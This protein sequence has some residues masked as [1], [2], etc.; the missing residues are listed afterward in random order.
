M[1][2]QEVRDGAIII[3]IIITTNTL[4]LAIVTV[5]ATGP[6]TTNLKKANKVN[7]GDRKVRTDSGVSSL[8]PCR[9]QQQFLQTVR[10]SDEIEE[11]RTEKARKEQHAG[12]RN[13]QRRFNSGL[14]SIGRPNAKS[15][16]NLKQKR[17]D[18]KIGDFVSMTTKRVWSGELQQWCRRKR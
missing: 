7:L 2:C 11:G 8:C 15:H 5:L 12:Q 14:W 13:Y 10:P 17:K 16:R 3:I 18:R 9:I 6:N 1:R 4:I